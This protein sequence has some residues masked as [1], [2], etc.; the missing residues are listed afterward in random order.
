VMDTEDIKLKARTDSLETPNA[1]REAISN[2]KYFA[3]VQVRDIK[4]AADGRV[5]FRLVLSLSK[6]VLGQTDKSMA[7]RQ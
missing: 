7:A 3:D 2:T 4:S 5:D 6:T 1:V